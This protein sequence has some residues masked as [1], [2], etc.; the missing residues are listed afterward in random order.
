MAGSQC[1][2]YADDI[3]LMARN[4]P[5]WIG[6]SSRT[7]GIVGKRNGTKDKRLMRPKQNVRLWKN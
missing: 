7:T 3:A 2:I 4:L 5:E 6:T 1:S